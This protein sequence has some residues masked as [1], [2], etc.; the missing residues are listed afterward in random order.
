MGLFSWTSIVSGKDIYNKYSTKHK[1]IAMLMPDDSL[2]VGDYDGYG[3]IL[4]PGGDEIDIYGKVAEIM[5]GKYN[6]DLIFS[7]KR[8]ITT[9]DNEPIGAVNAFNWGE[10][11]TSENI[12]E[13]FDENISFVGKSLNELIKEGYESTTVFDLAQVWIK[14]M[15]RT[16][17]AKHI[18]SGKTFDDYKHSENAYSQGHG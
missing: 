5:F 13:M 12:I 9:S 1:G 11:L 17:V 2:I 7:D 8:T 18:K 16:E 10:K 4:T 6:R 14:V 15:T 3:R